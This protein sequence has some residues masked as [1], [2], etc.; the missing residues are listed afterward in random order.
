MKRF[1]EWWRGRPQLRL[2]FVVPGKETNPLAEQAID[3]LQ[4][5]TKSLEHSLGLVNELQTQFCRV[6]AELAA[7]TVSSMDE[8]VQVAELERMRLQNTPQKDV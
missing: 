1:L 3:C 5:A 6:Q 8:D 2:H 7:Y 4:Q